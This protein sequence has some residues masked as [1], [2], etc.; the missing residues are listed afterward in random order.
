MSAASQAPHHRLRQRLMLVFA[1]FALLVAALYGFYVAVFV[2]MV[3]DRFFDG[4]LA[5]EAEIQ[6]R[7]HAEHG[8]WAIPR[9][10]FI[11]VHTD[12]ATLPDGL[13]ARLAPE[14]WRREFSGAEGRHYHLARLHPAAGEPGLP[15]WLAAEVGPQLVVRPIRGGIL[16]WL[17][18][19]GL[20]VL[21]LALSLGA[22]LARR[23]TAPLSRLAQLVDET[24]PDRLPPAF[25]QN[26]PDDEVGVLARGLERLIARIDAFVSREREFTRDA[27]HELRTPLAVIRSA[28]ERLGARRDLDA[29]ARSQIA[30]V[31]QSAR[32]LEQTVTTLLSLARECDGT[33]PAT[34]LS[35]LPMIERVIVEQAPLLEARPVDLLVDVPVA[36]RVRLPTTVLHIVLSNLMGN[37]FAHTVQGRVVID[38]AD[39]ALRIS[40]PG[41]GLQEVDFQP[42]V[43]RQASAGFGLGLSIVRRLCE[44]HGI[45]LRIESH[46]RQTV[47]SVGLTGITPRGGSA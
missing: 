39:D 30:Y 6:Q 8:V 12:P 46:G 31:E 7:H 9:L 38:L 3:E 44:R 22:W 21:G 40:N 23:V 43:K 35:L 19:S 2:Y 32:Q 26:F 4:L 14:P 11:T 24:S 41:D 27:S 5:R 16:Q 29:D 37:A 13:G 20:A 42:F 1:G 45:P 15:A 25:S 33:Q 18:W 17:A 47:A 34:E 28:C 36:T 10:D